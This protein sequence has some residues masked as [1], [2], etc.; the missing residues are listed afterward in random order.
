[1]VDFDHLGHEL[2]F[3]I[4]TIFM[5]ICSKHT[6]PGQVGFVMKKKFCHE[7]FLTSSRGILIARN[8]S[9]EK[10]IFLCEG[11]EQFLHRRVFI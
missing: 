11:M 5:I 6:V 2:F 10:K 4:S 1:M 9:K 3:I 8:F 7:T